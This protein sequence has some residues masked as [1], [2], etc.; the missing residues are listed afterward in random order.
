MDKTNGLDNKEELILIGKNILY[1]KDLLRA[2]S[3]ID[4]LPENSLHENDKQALENIIK[5]INYITRND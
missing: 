4:F 3:W 2:I 5:I 1:K